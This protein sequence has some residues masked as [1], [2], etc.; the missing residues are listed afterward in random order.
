MK[1]RSAV[2]VEAPVRRGPR[3]PYAKSEQTRNAIIEAALEIFAESGYR[4]SSLRMVAERAGITDS[5]LLR[6]FPNK[7]TLLAAALER[8]DE[9]TQE[10]FNFDRPRGRESLRELIR[11]AEYNAST[12]GV[13]ELFCTLSAE[14]TSPEHPAHEYFE[15]R[16]RFTRTLLRECFEEIKVSGGLRAGTD[17]EA[18]ARS[19]LALLDGLQ[20]QWLLDA[21][22]VD[23]P[24]DVRAFVNGLL[25]VGV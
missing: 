22:A 1:T 24:G 14:A 10:N 5:G 8:R 18:A 11:L 12:P 13:V 6:H 2:D 25:V 20:I 16:Y 7:K 9:Q 4:S 19:T 3:G 23:M 21:E 17:P 15:R